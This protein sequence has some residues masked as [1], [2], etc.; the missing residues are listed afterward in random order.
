MSDR[1]SILRGGS[2]PSSKE[3]R[4]IR[5]SLLGSPHLRQKL[6]NAGLFEDCVAIVED[7][8][9]DN[10]LAVAAATTAAV[11]AH[12]PSDH[13]FRASQRALLCAFA[14]RDFNSDVSTL[15]LVLL[16]EVV[17]QDPKPSLR[18]IHSM[19]MISGL[20]RR[21]MPC[22]KFVAQCLLGHTQGRPPH[23]PL[24]SALYA[25][26]LVPSIQINA[27]PG[28]MARHSSKVERLAAIELLDTCDLGGILPCFEDY[29]I[30]SMLLLSRT[31]RTSSSARELMEWPLFNTHI[32]QGINRNDP[33]YRM[34]SLQLLAKMM[35]SYDNLRSY[36][37]GQKYVLSTVAAIIRSPKEDNQA[38]MIACLFV[39]SL[40]RSVHVLRLLKE[41]D[42]SAC[43]MQLVA[44]GSP[45][46]ADA[47][48]GALCNLVLEFSPQRETLL[49]SDLLRLACQ[50]L[51]GPD[52]RLNALWLLHNATCLAD[53]TTVSA[54]ARYLSD[55]TLSELCSHSDPLVAEQAFRV[56]Q[57]VATKTELTPTLINSVAYHCRPEYVLKH[58]DSGIAALEALANIAVT[59][60]SYLL[61]LPD[62]TC[63]LRTMF[64]GCKDRTPIITAIG[65]ILCSL[66][67]SSVHLPLFQLYSE[68]VDDD[69]IEIAELARRLRH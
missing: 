25:R 56:A 47:A 36:L 43:L 48:L 27:D 41:Q 58:N 35:D 66:R 3:L 19:R 68:L 40:T 11:L 2:L 13:D 26:C 53:T 60:G 10:D 44:E 18:N 23:L 61:S 5:I 6:L 1:A 69:R 32:V 63:S 21:R 64:E 46:V 59:N 42:L 52:T 29:P 34:A 4:G 31:I 17:R 51:T 28:Q 62:L 45:D 57:N 7:D 12:D 24:D 67:L 14:T 20:L 50:K 55:T 22:L 8:Q 15:G 49:K 16:L 33:E 65:Y 37:L 39:R 54:V 38:K 9:T 30:H